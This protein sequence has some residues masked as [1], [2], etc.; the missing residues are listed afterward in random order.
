MEDTLDINLLMLGLLRDDGAI[1]YINGEE[2]LRSN[3]PSGN[4]AYLTQASEAVYGESENVCKVINS[5]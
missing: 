3:M 2:V 5:H 1:V 4:I